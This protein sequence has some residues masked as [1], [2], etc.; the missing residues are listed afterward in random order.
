MNTEQPDS[1]VIDVTWSVLAVAA[2]VVIALLLRSQA[3]PVPVK[4]TPASWIVE[5]GGRIELPVDTTGPTAEAPRLTLEVEALD[6]DTGQRINNATTWPDGYQV[7][8]GCCPT[9]TIEASATHT[10]TV[11]A[12]DYMV[13][14]AMLQPR[15]VTHSAVIR[16]PARLRRMGLEI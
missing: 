10:L 3:T 7:A 12:P 8:E 5:P 16:A 6:D 1:K 13:F 2:V 15:K 11:R 4:T 9:V 14:E